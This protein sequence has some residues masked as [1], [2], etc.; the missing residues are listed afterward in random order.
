MGFGVGRNI[1][2]E[3][4]GLGV[5]AFGYA[6]GKINGVNLLYSEIPEVKAILCWGHK[7][8][9]SREVG[10]LAVVVENFD[11]GKVIIEI[12]DFYS[13]AI[14]ANEGLVQCKGLVAKKRREVQEDI[15]LS[16]T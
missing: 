1:L 7:P 8:N 10:L 15:F 5:V 9:G 2:G 14:I 16:P 13:D 4:S 3:C 11:I 6:N 12:L